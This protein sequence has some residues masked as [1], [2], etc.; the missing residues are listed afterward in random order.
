MGIGAKKLDPIES[1]SALLRDDGGSS[2][3]AL[4]G[5]AELTVPMPNVVLKK[6]HLIDEP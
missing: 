1:R 5:E 2:S 3:V 4:T 6:Q